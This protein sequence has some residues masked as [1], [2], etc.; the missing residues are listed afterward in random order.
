MRYLIIGAAAFLAVAAP[1][2]ATAQTGYAGA[3]YGNIDDGADSS[4]VYGGEGSVAFQASD[5][6]SVEVDASILDGDVSDTATGLTGHVYGRNDDHLFGGFVGI[7]DSGSS[8]TWNAG[9]EAN[10]Y[11]SNW[12]LAGAVFYANNDDVDADG[13]GVNAE[14]RLFPTD[15]FRVQGNVGLASAN[16]SGNDDTAITLGVGGEYQ[17]DGSPVSIALGYNHTELTDANDEVDALW[18]GIR[19]NWGGTLRERDRKGASQAGIL[20][21][22]SSFLGL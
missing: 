14:A 4:E 16:F 17:F 5:T 19:F 13:Y 1:G 18:V 10:K 2:I 15:N 9:L 11:F 21:F 3:A 12:T 22:G 20:G 6:I 8:Q 7:A